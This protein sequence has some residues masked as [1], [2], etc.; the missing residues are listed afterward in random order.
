MIAIAYGD[1]RKGVDLFARIGL[2]VMARRAD[3]VFVWIGK[4]E[5]SAEAET[6]AI[7]SASR[8]GDRFL[9]PGFFDDLEDC[10]AGA[11]VF[12]LT[13]R[14]DP[15]PNVLLD[16]LDAATPVVAF[17]GAGGFEALLKQGGGRLVADF[18]VAGFSAEVET[19]LADEAMRTQLGEEGRRQ[20]DRDYS[21]H[22]YVL[23]INRLLHPDYKRVSVVVPNYN[24]A[25]YLPA[26]L[27][28]IDRQGYAPYEIVLLD[29][30]SQDDS[31][32]AASATLPGLRTPVDVVINT[33]NSGSVFRQWRKGVER[34]RG[35]LVWIA[36]ADDLSEPGFLEAVVAPFR[37]PDV[38][39]S[40]CQS[41]MI[42]DDGRIIGPDY[43]AYVADVDPHKWTAAYVAD[44]GDEI[45][46]ALSIKNTIPN[47]SAVVFRRDVLL[48]VLSDGFDEID[49]YRVAGDWVTYLKVLEL[50]KVAFDPRPLNSHR[51]HAAGVTIGAFNAG[52]LREII[53]V[54]RSVAGRAKLPK[55]QSERAGAYAQ[56]LYVQFGLDEGCGRRVE[57]DPDFGQLYK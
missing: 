2:E 33:A 41:N 30:A 45:A 56:S 26:R 37:N 46:L 8:F 20:I 21:F 28:S 1:H 49:A 17:A 39:L 31:L 6:M 29:D 52:Q 40:Y 12:A 15:F 36:E 11:D 32:A 48:K 4:M 9:F 22:R 44:G 24:Y 19:L 35:D 53:S 51:R 42:D 13:S 10:Y 50:G 57:D 38:V 16:A 3:T 27:T 25:R 14:E 54:Q 18:S 5:A 7:I 47:V 23:D 43:L 34:A 55:S